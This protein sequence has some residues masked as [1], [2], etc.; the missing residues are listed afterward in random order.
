MSC[1][2]VTS[3]FSIRTTFFEFNFIICLLTNHISISESD[4]LVSFSGRKLRKI[5][6]Y[7]G[8]EWFAIEKVY[9]KTLVVY[10]KSNEM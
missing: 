6:N 3:S 4:G 8:L 1:V 7:V 5:P 2:S 9:Y 10:S